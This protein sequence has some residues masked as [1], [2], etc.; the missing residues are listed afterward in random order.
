MIVVKEIIKNLIESTLS[1][2]IK[3]EISKSI[4]NSDVCKYYETS[5]NDKTKFV[6][7][8]RLNKDLSLD[9]GMSHLSIYNKDLINGYNLF[10]THDFV[11]IEDLGESIYEIYVK[12]SLPK[13]NEDVTYSEILNSTFSKQ[14][15]RDKKLS[16]ILSETEPPKSNKTEKVNDVSPDKKKSFFSK[17]FGI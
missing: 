17:L 14:S 5:P 1:G 11:E 3:W 13:K 12:K 16:S 9:K 7:Q 15:L 10:M 2:D 4:F 6:V 8:V